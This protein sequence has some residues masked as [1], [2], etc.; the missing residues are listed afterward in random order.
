[1]KPG[2]AAVLTSRI[3]SSTSLTPP[4]IPLAQSIL[5]RAKLPLETIA[6]AVCIL[7]SLNGRFALAFRHGCPL[8]AP[9]SSAAATFHPNHAPHIDS[10]HPELLILSA[11]ILA[12]K[13]LDD[14]QRSTA[15]YAL[16]WGMQIWTS[17]QINYTQISIM[18]NIDY[19]IFP[20][21]DEELIFMILMDMR[22]AGQQH[23]PHIYDEDNESMLDR[24]NLL[25]FENDTPMSSGKAGFGLQDQLTTAET[26]M[27]KDFDGLRTLSVE[28][29]RAFGGAG[30]LEPCP[31][32]MDPSSE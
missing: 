25:E 7:D 10:I 2:P 28:T 19:R 11:L 1:M 12:V 6:L 30:L 20:L 4:S 15:Y 29:K 31:V 32:Y 23:E 16:H 18:E 24:V 17:A 9:A 26:P 3:P 5:T 8:A 14:D 21:W 27:I 22:R 13:F